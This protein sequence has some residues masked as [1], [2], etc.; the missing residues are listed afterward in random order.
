MFGGEKKEQRYMK[1]TPCK[2]FSMGVEL[3]RFGPVCMLLHRQ[4]LH[5]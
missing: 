3:F 2:V 5:G 1:R 4:A